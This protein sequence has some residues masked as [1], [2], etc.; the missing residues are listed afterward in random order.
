M[1][2]AETVGLEERRGDG[3]HHWL[4][5]FSRN[6]LVP[7]EPDAN[8]REF[9]AADFLRRALR[10]VMDFLES[11]PDDRL[12]SGEVVLSASSEP[13]PG[14]NAVLTGNIADS[15]REEIAWP[16][17]RVR[18]DL[19]R[20]LVRTVALP[21]RDP[22]RLPHDGRSKRITQREDVRHVRLRDDQGVR[23]Q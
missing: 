11:L 4:G 22:D 3:W 1:L 18:F 19:D 14:P 20:C 21:L 16:C 7:G 8:G 17:A 12:G 23:L 2:P 10:L 15:D 13:P 5:Q 6:D 9:G